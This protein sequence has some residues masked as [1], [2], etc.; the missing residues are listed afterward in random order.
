MAITGTKT[1]NVSLAS[2]IALRCWLLERMGLTRVRVLD[3]CAGAGH[4]W[5]TMRE[6]VTVD[7]WVRC[8]EKPRQAGTLK[9][10]ALDAVKSLPL[11]G[12]NVIDIDPY[13]T[14][15]AIYREALRRVRA[16]GRTEPIAFFLTHGHV[17][18]SQV[19]HADLAAVGIPKDWPVPITP[20]LSAFV[21]RA[22][23]AQ[24]WLDAE[25]LHAAHV[26]FPRVS[27]YALGVRPLGGGTHG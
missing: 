26:M 24:T 15:F 22:A 5:R 23:V 16:A 18:Q 10:Q 14:P 19:S 20:A 9:M 21:A 2:K 6:H 1:D 12:F 11:D 13:G 4:V 17:A 27:Y 25:V 3:T 8:D 7:Q